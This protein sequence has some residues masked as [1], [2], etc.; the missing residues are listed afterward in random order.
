[1][2]VATR[3]CKR[4]D[5]ELLRDGN[6]IPLAV[7]R[8]HSLSDAVL[9]R[10]RQRDSAQNELAATRMTRTVKECQDLCAVGFLPHKGVQQEALQSYVLIAEGTGRPHA[11]AV[12]PVGAEGAIVFYHEDKR[13]V[14]SVDDFRA[15]LAGSTDAKTVVTFRVM[16]SAHAVEWPTV[17]GKTVL[18]PLL[19]VQAGAGA[20][21][22]HDGEDEDGAEQEDEEY[23]VFDIVDDCAGNLALDPAEEPFEEGGWD[24]D[25]DIEAACE[26]EVVAGTHLLQGLHREV[27][28]FLESAPVES[29][30]DEGVRSYPCP[31]CPFRRFDRT[32]RLRHHV[33]S[34]HTE[35]R[36]F[37][38]S[39][40]K[41]MKVVASMYDSDR[42]LLRVHS[43]DL[44]QRSATL[45]R[46]TVRP[47]LSSAQ[48]DIDKN[49]RLI[50]TAEGP[51]YRNMQI[52]STSSSYRRVRNLYYT[53]GFAEMLKE[54]VLLSGAR[55]KTLLPHLVRKAMGC[56]N[57]LTS[58]Y[59][60]HVSCWWPIIEDIFTSPAVVKL[61]ERIL[62]KYVETEELEYLSM[63][64]T[65]KCT[66]PLLGQ[67]HP[68]APVGIRLLDAFQGEAAIKRVLTVRGRTGAVA[69][70]FPL[71]KEDHV[72]IAEALS[73][74]LPE[75]LRRTIRFVA[76]DNP[77]QALFNGLLSALPCLQ[78]LCL[79]PVHLPLT[80]EYAFWRRHTAGSSA[81]RRL[82]VRFTHMSKHYAAYSWG[83]VYA[84]GPA[85]ALTG[86]E[87][88]L[89]DLILTSG[90]AA[91]TATRLLERC[92]ASSPF[93]HRLEFL[94]G[95][96]ALSSVHSAEMDRIV[97][98][99]NKKVRTLL[100][101]AGDP[102]R[103]E[104]FLNNIRV[105]AQMEAS[106]WELLPSGTSSNEA[107]HAELNVCF[108]Q[109][110]TL[111]Q[112]TLR[113]KLQCLT[114]AKQLSHESAMY[115]PSLRQVFV[116]NPVCR[117]RMR[118]WEGRS[119]RRQD[120]GFCVCM[121]E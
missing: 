87:R 32:S 94:E 8:L 14:I 25:L 36:Q 49:I 120:S 74:N 42:A 121:C 50:L 57:E 20:R 30:M 79:D 45:L 40:T 39:G 81:L 85:R 10:I 118:G 95:L 68:L 65:L 89:R 24:A 46:R 47:P 34:Y 71:A 66:M 22:Q 86:E 80:Y 111:H 106:R 70:M 1:M 105:R 5:A 55:A 104:W 97:P 112:S 83:A 58:L 103:M 2:E 54:E 75:N 88:R 56:G 51:E 3:V 119:P 37:V 117:H 78:I 26:A 28:V 62:A 91:R 60:T 59:P 29:V 72:H 6:C 96:A 44:L 23:V 92:Q 84:G 77:S 98:G 73:T 69:G 53:K 114:L 67:S 31:F 107:L 116:A 27:K 38:A 99:P 11:I 93:L 18:E 15:A 7:S 21:A 13:F 16:A 17:P 109:T 52:V 113:L 19:E 82:M 115:H 12:D 9:G 102:E 110:Q 64:S 41:Q 48:K 108:R 76:V 90:M 63:D 101:N 61:T 33:R 43:N 35:A 4:Q 100:W